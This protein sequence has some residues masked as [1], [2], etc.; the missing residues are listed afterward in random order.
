[1]MKIVFLVSVLLC[2]AQAVNTKTKKAVGDLN[3]WKN[4]VFYQIYPRSFKDSNNDGI[5]DLKG[6]IS[7]LQH[8]KNAGVTA[9]WLSPVYESPQVDQGYDIS[10]YTNIDKDYGTLEDFDELVKAAHD[11]GLKVVM[12]FVPNHSSNLHQ[13]FIN[14]EKKV[15]GYEDY[16]IWKDGK[17]DG[18]PP[19]NWISVFSNSAWK[20][21]EIRKQYYLHHFT[22]EQP[23][24][25]LG[26]PKV[27]LAL[28][29][30]LKFWLDR[31]VD[32]FR[33]D[34]VPYL[35]E[36][37]EWRD[38][39]LSGTTNDSTSNAYLNHIYTQNLPD[40]FKMIYRWRE[41]LD[42]Y[43]RDNGGD[44]RIMMTEAYANITD[45]MKYY[46]DGDIEGAHFTFN[47]QFITYL[48]NKSSAH[49]I[50]FEVNQWLHYMP[51]KYVPNWVLGNHDNIR[52]ATKFGPKRVDGMNTFT[53]FLPGVMVTYNGEE[54]GQENGEVTYAQG[55]DPNAC[56][57]PPEQFDTLSRD[58]ERTPYH[59]D[60]ST[61]A[62]F[63]A[64]AEPWLPVSKKY[65]ETNLAAQSAEGVFSHFY[66]YKEIV[67]LRRLDTFKKGNL[68]IKALNNNVVAYT[69]TLKGS[70][71]YI[72]VI[73]ISGR[74][75]EVDLSV[76]PEVNKTARIVISTQPSKRG[77]IIPS[78]IV[79]LVPYESFVAQV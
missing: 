66:L 74:W 65:K 42:N 17:S 46:G 18:S 29:D 2:S 79:N 22:V 24:L 40:T 26:N 15:S 68:T 3:W 27:D 11:L 25:N 77:R 59:W 53:A 41:Y 63:N 19:N 78:I 71:T 12:D 43:T 16:Y 39:P 35:F 6:I 75:E 36:D 37:K 61:N 70:P 49:D 34:A 4:A 48:S 33:M 62:G 69:R 47:F 31:G 58:F 10:N 23:D 57:A 7:K 64:G 5:G 54:I 1:M 55:Q 28:L 38:E 56:N 44:A 21:S 60:N 52:V 14:S 32:G 30:V 8:L 13:W 67:E 9:A 51:S 73:N 76:F 50:V 72:V 20:Y 45:T